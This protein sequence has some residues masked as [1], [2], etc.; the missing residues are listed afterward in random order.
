M[1]KIILFIE[2]LGLSGTCFSEAVSVRTCNNGLEIT[3]S[4]TGKDPPEPEIG[5]SG[6]KASQYRADKKQPNHSHTDCT[7]FNDYLLYLPFIVSEDLLQVKKISYSAPQE[8]CNFARA[9]PVP[10]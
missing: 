5:I 9:P 1:G 8:S 3:V 6:I 7:G 4:I 10:V 2:I